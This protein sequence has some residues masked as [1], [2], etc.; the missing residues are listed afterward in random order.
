VYYGLFEPALVMGLAANVA[1]DGY[2]TG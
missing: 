2:T 1:G